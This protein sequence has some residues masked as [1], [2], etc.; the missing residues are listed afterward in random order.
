[1]GIQLKSQTQVESE[2]FTSLRKLSEIGLYISVR[3]WLWNPR[4][5]DY[6]SIGQQAIVLLKKLHNFTDKVRKITNNVMLPHFLLQV[7]KE[8]K[9]EILQKVKIGSGK[10]VAEQL[11]SCTEMQ[12][13]KKKR[14]MAFLDLVL[15][16]HLKNPKHFKEK[17]VGILK[18]SFVR[19]V[20]HN[21][22]IFSFSSFGSNIPLTPKGARRSRHLYFCRASYN[23]KF[24]LLDTSFDC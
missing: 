2:Y 21:A 22:L 15:S 11:E 19:F 17:H 13:S 14:Q 8:R 6:T 20:Y 5:L 12:H 7:I 23:C 3:P 18:A 1:M 4:L 9:A 24:G 16:H 10:S